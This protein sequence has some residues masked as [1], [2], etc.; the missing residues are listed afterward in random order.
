MRRDSRVTPPRPRRFRLASVANPRH[1][2]PDP[3]WSSTENSTAMARQ[4]RIVLAMQFY[5]RYG[6]DV[7]R[8]AIAYAR[9]H[10]NW[11]LWHMRELD[12][13]EVQGT[14]TAGII[15]HTLT[16][17]QCQEATA[18]GLSVVVAGNTA[19][20][21]GLSTVSVD[22]TATGEMAAQHLMDL[23]LRDFAFAGTGDWPWVRGRLAGFNAALA[24]MGRAPAKAFVG[25]LYEPHRRLRFEASLERWLRQLPRPCGVLAGNDATG[26]VVIAAARRLG[27]RVPDELA[28]VGVDDDELACELSDIPLSSI[29][30]PLTTIGREAARLL[31]RAL[32][33]PTRR[34]MRLTVPPIRVV[35]RA[36]SDMVAMK[37]QD[38]A[39]TLRLIRDHAAEPINVAWIV[40][41]L[42]VARRSLERRFRQ[43]VG[44]SLLEQI[45]HV[46]FQKAQQLLAETDLSLKQIAVQTGF[47]DPHWLAA[48]FRQHLKTTPSDYRRQFRRT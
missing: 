42:T 20:A 10:T 17:E 27:I 4:K 9:Q 5:T 37:E 38:V 41:H 32:K 39:E 13:A 40:D 43:V 21:S 3:D 1:T 2:D 7:A 33:G 46:R 28:V 22:D 19:L 30:Q 44:R 47:T 23:G 14:K 48:C 29:A 8:G 24:G 25:S 11:R 16:D 15:C 34:P 36:S 45:H 12:L 35:P 31:H 26:V 6:R 18:M